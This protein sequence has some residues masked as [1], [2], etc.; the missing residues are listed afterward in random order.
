MQNLPPAI[1][2]TISILDP[3]SYAS[4][5]AIPTL[6]DGFVYLDVVLPDITFDAKYATDDNFTGGVVHGYNANRIV[7]SSAMCEPLAR[8]KSLAA[9]QGYTLLIWD[10]ARPQRAVDH[11]VSWINRPED[12]K[13]KS[14]HYPKLKKKQLLK[15]YIAKRSGHSRGCA[16]DL[17]LVDENGEML[18][19]GGIFDLMDKR[20]HHGAKGLTAQQTA[21]RNTLKSIMDN[22]GFRAYDKEWWHYILRDEP[23]PDTYFDFSI[24]HTAP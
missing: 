8:A 16:V 1:V 24:E 3:V 7:I 6:P 9:Q 20:S 5:P 17:T 12:G 2:E 19:M 22:A 4:I 10:A 14:I 18:D 13:T 11:F 15:V 23:F 21:N